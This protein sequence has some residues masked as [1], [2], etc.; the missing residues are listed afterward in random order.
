MPKKLFQTKLLIQLAIPEQV[1]DP[2]AVD[3]GTTA[4]FDV[5]DYLFEEG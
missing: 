4:G 3:D 2:V 5:D 1:G